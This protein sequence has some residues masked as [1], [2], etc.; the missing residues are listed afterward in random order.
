MVSNLKMYKLAK[1]DRACDML[2]NALA[3]NDIV[4][5]YKH[6]GPMLKTK[7]KKRTI[8]VHNVQAKPCLTATKEK[9]IF[10]DEFKSV[11]NGDVMTFCDLA[12]KEI[13]SC[14]EPLA[15]SPSNCDNSIPLYDL[16]VHV[17]ACRILAKGSET[18]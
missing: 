14:E 16:F 5:M 10:R 13:K 11:M 12:V 8:R 9:E 1:I 3:S 6:V 18:P 17:L 15:V 2:Q 7:Y 4:S